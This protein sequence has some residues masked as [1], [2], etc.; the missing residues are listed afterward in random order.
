MYNAASSVYRSALNP[1]PNAL[2]KAE[3]GDFV[4]DP[5]KWKRPDVA[6]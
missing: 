3:S 6:H 2:R 4:C 5:E 1:I